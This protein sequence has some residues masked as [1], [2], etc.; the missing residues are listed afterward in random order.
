MGGVP[1][2]DRMIDH[3]RQINGAATGGRW[4]V[5]PA[6]RSLAEVAYEQWFYD[7][8]MDS[9]SALETMWHDDLVTFC[10]PERLAELTRALDEQDTGIAGIILLDSNCTVHRGRSFHNGRAR[11]A[12]DRPQLI[13]NFRA[14]QAIGNWAPPLIVMSRHRAAAVSTQKVARVYCLESLQFIE[15]VSLRSGLI[16]TNSRKVGC[17]SGPSNLSAVFSS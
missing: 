15:G 11:I 1:T 3:V 6:T 13:V 7:S 16:P 17:E 4:I 10:V 5:V 14:S 9:A 12:H 8:L 2:F